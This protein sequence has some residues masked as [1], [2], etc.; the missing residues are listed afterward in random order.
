MGLALPGRVSFELTDTVE[1]LWKKRLDQHTGDR[2]KGRT[3][4]K[5]PEDLRV[6]QHVIEASRPDTIVELGTYGGGSAIWFADQLD[7]FC[8]GGRVVTCDIYL[9]PQPLEDPRVR[10]LHGSLQDMS[11]Q[12]GDLVR[13]RVMVVDDSA[14]TY[15]STSAALNLYYHL[16]T[17]GCWFVVEDGVVDESISIWAGGGVQPAI[18]DFLRTHDDFVQ[19]DLAVYGLTTDHNGW[20]ERR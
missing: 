12:I 13:G 14:H 6:Y 4:A 20:L 19:H 3:L 8:G 5:M 2:Y 10:F 16:V 18:R 1:S 9:P 17:P 11:G 15:E 7:T